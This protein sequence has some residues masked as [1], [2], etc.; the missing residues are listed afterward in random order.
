MKS[1]PPQEPASIYDLALLALDSSDSGW[2]EADGPKPDLARFVQQ[3]LQGKAEMMDD[4]FSMQ[5][6]EVRSV[7]CLG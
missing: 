6:D 1:P 2:T 7:F 5:I 4:Y 3:L